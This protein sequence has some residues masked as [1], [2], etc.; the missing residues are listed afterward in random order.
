[1]TR[2]QQDTLLFLAILAIFVLTAMLTLA[3]VANWIDVRDEFLAPL[4]TGLL[5]ET[6]AVIFLRFRQSSGLLGDAQRAPDWILGGWWELVFSHASVLVNFVSISYSQD[7]GRLVL[8]GQAYGV[9]PAR[10]ATWHSTASALSLPT[11]E[12]FYSWQGDEVSRTA[13]HGFEG[14]G[15]FTF[16]PPH[17]DGRVLNGSGWFTTA[18]LR[19]P[20]SLQRVPCE[21]RRI[22]AEHDSIM[23][24][25][26]ADAEKAAL[27]LQVYED[28]RRQLPESL[29]ARSLSG[30]PPDSSGR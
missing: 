10:V 5:L 26:N 17:R 28:W 14:F 13:G 7:E 22:S 12:L 20:E 6:A 15:K 19:D 30:A 27:A 21:L 29:G 3:G 23:N 25:D 9:G 2:T 1:V 16:D 18:A 24:K 8:T 4:V 11:R